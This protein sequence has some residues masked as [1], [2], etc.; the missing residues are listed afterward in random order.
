M[1]FILTIFCIVAILRGK[2]ELIDDHCLF[3]WALFSVADAMWI[4]ILWRVFG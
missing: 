4:Q 1:S 2:S 3:A